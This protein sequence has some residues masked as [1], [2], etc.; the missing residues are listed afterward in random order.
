MPVSV[1]WDNRHQ[2]PVT[3]IPESY[4][5]SGERNTGANC[6]SQVI[7]HYCSGNRNVGVSC[8]GFFLGPNQPG[9]A[10]NIFAEH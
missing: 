10:N 9:F 4:N 3:Y 2:E 7:C 5:V 6:W 1:T 8:E